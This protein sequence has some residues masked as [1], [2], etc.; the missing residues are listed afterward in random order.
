MKDREKSRITRSEMAKFG[1]GD[2]KALFPEI[3]AGVAEHLR[4][5]FG[6]RL[7]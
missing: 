6:F 1:S 3:I 7:K 2:L 4:H 5:G